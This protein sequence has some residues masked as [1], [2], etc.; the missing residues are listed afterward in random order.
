MENH[1]FSDARGEAGSD[2]GQFFARK[3]RGKGGFL[4]G[5]SAKTGNSGKTQFFRKIC[6]FPLIYR[7]TT[8]KKWKSQIFPRARDSVGSVG[9]FS[10]RAKKA[11]RGSRARAKKRDFRENREKSPKIVIFPE[12]HDF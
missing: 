6:D 3:C 5:F 10:A 12:N 9:A 11:G 7:L 2:R 1:R 4:A 8:G